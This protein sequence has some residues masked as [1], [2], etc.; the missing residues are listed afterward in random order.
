MVLASDCS[1]VCQKGLT[2]LQNDRLT[3][4]Q[5]YEDIETCTYFAVLGIL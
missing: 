4:K 1:A 2:S 3:L 5:H